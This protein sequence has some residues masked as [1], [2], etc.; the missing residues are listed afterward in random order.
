MSANAKVVKPVTG[1]SSLVRPRYSPGLLLRDDDLKQGVDYTR[2]LSR[3]LFRSLFGCGVVCGLK[4][5]WAF[6]CDKLVLTVDDG[7]AL[8][9]HG[10]PVHVPDAQSIPIDP[11]CGD[12][13]PPHMYVTLRRI[14]KCCAPRAAACSC[15]DDESPAVC[16]RERDGFEIRVVTAWPDC[17]CGCKEQPPDETAPPPPPSAPAPPAGLI[18]TGTGSAARAAGARSSRRVLAQPAVSVQ[19]DI[20]ESAGGATVAADDCQCADPKDKC[21]VD[22]YNGVCACDCGECDCE[23]IVLARVDDRSTPEEKKWSVDHSV[24]RFARP[25]L[26]RDPATLPQA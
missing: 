7:V 9:C 13:I 22:H 17:A 18:V 12:P 23:W 1:Q 21:Y 26:M 2:D 19:Q 10:D 20:E 25:V 24:R 11:S 14:E 15:D 4:V 5:S 3:L 8:D 6:K 16:T